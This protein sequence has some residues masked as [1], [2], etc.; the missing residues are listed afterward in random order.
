[1]VGSN[2]SC[3]DEGYTSEELINPVKSL[4][5]RMEELEVDFACCSNEE[6]AEDI[7]FLEVDVLGSPAYDEEVMSDTDQEQTN[8]DGYPS[9]DDEEQI[10]SIVLFYDDYE[11]DPWE[12]HEGEKE[13]PN[14]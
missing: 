9:E 10:F 12:S 14:A 3:E 4:S 13:D 5:A 1:M 2:E 8:F 6:N 11:S 7:S